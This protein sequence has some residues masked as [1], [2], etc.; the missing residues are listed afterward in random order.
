MDRARRQ[1]GSDQP[2]GATAWGKRYKRDLLDV[3]RALRYD[4]AR[5]SDGGLGLS[6]TEAAEYAAQSLRGTPARTTGAAVLKLISRMK[7]NHE[8]AFGRYYL[9]GG[10]IA[11]EGSISRDGSQGRPRNMQRS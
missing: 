2:Y 8:R 10:S 3:V 7:A 4:E 11:W 9:Y 1:G 6:R 5:D